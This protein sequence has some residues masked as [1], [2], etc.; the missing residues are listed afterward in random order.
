[1]PY[2]VVFG[3][4]PRWGDNALVP[5]EAEKFTLVDIIDE[6]GDIPEP[7]DDK[8]YRMEDFV[9]PHSFD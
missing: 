7:N 2:E 3:Q 8:F 5:V 6:M 1:M 4:K 9:K